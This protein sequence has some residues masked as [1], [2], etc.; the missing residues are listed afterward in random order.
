CAVPTCPWCDNRAP[1]GPRSAGQHGVAEQSRLDA[2]R[3]P[4][5]EWLESVVSLRPRNR[6][7]LQQ[8]FP[9]PIRRRIPEKGSLYYAG[10]NK[11]M[12]AKMES[13]RRNSRPP[14]RVRAWRTLWTSLRRPSTGEFR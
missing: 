5:S 10:L 9:Y 13:Q 7:V 4:T 11:A 8:D 1:N 6:E 14:R 2:V 12:T 3:A